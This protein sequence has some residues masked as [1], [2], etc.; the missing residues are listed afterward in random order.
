MLC[1][2]WL[3]TGSDMC[4]RARARVCVCACICVYARACVFVYRRKSVCMCVCVRARAST[5]VFVWSYIISRA[6][7]P[8]SESVLRQA[9]KKFPFPVL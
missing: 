6:S 3:L 7:I 8:N 4:A 2:Y 5:R 1:F 9:I